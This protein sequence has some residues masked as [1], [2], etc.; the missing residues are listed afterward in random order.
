MYIHDAWGMS[1]AKLQLLLYKYII[2]YF[3]HYEAL[4]GVLHFSKNDS[5]P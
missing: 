1:L 4:L 2:L 3:L 5:A